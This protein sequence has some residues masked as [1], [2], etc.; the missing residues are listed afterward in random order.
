MFIKCLEKL[1]ALSKAWKPPSSP[2]TEQGG[3]MG[4][5][6]LLLQIHVQS[7]V[8]NSELC[9]ILDHFRAQLKSSF[10]RR[11]RLV[12]GILD[13]EITLFVLWGCPVV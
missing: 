4:L 8:N 1:T 3:L 12:Q 5:F 10:C 7:H 2:A 9:S 13:L 6:P 11:L